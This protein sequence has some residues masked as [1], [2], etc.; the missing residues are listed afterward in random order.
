MP[1]A[2][3]AELVIRFKWISWKRTFL[4]QSTVHRNKTSLGTPPPNATHGTQSVA[5]FPFMITIEK[6]VII[7]N[8]RKP[9]RHSTLKCV[10]PACNKFIRKN[11]QIDVIRELQG[12]TILCILL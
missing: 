11:R 12:F 2:N 8:G 5:D 1:V 3:K 6:C 10:S 9:T 4:S 7:V